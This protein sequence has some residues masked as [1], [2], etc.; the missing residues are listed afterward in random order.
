MPKRSL[1]IHKRK[2]GRWE[3]RFKA[4]ISENGKVKYTSLYAH[5]YE[6]AKKKLMKALTEIDVPKSKSNDRPFSEILQLWLENNQVRQKGSTTYKY[7]VVI[8]HHINPELGI[9]KVSQISS[10][11]IHSFLEKKQKMGRLDQNGGLSASYV[12]TMAIII[13]SALTFAANEGFCKPLQSPIYKP[14]TAKKELEILDVEDQK[15]LEE[16]IKQK[17]DLTCIGIFITLYAGLRIGEICALR[18]EDIDLERRVIHIRHTISR[19]QNI[20]PI[21]KNKTKLILDT[22]KTGTSLRDI[23]I[24]SLLFTLLDQIKTENKR[25]FVLSSSASFISPRTYEYR[26]HKIL[27]SCSIK[28]V[29]YHA[30]RHTFATRCVEAGVDVKSLSEILGHSDVST[31]LNTYVHSSMELKRIQ[32]E[33]L[34]SENNNYGQNCGQSS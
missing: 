12:R 19:V 1:N 8:E 4:G 10:A 32:I 31:T 15:R 24:A 5:T 9:L 25:E 28:Q 13:Q 26:F 34:N 6:E 27:E 29:N 22:P 17:G 30:L 16:Y 23:P 7:Q 33:K 2:D 3:A 20:D 21:S 11:T 18:W 14:A